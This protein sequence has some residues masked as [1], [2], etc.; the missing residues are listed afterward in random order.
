MNKNE[1]K[2]GTLVRNRW[3]GEIFEVRE[4]THKDDQTFAEIVIRDTIRM[5][6]FDKNWEVYRNAGG[7]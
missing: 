4:F 7:N 2:V 3:T 1:V 5:D 6:M